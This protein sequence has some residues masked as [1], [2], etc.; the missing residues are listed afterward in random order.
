MTELDVDFVRRQFA[1]LDD[2]EHWAYFENAGGSL[3]PRQVTDKL[4]HFFEKTKVQPYYP[5]E[6]SEAAGDAMDRSQALL[7]ASVNASPAE[8]HFGPSTTMNVYVLAAA[9]RSQMSDGDEVIVT[10]QDHEANIGAWAR[11]ADTG[12]TVRTWEADEKSGFLDTDELTKLL[13]NRTRLVC[14][15]HCS[16]VVG[17][18]NPIREIAD[19]V[20]RAGAKI[21]VDGV[22][23]APHAPVDV[24]AL[25]VD[26]YLY[27]LYK[28]WGPHLGLMYVR[29][30]LAAELPNQGH[31]FNAGDAG[32][33]LVPAGP[34]HGEIA[35]ASGIVDY[36]DAIYTHHFGKP[37]GSVT[38]RVGAVFELFAK[39]E[40]ALTAML[41]QF[42]AD[43]PGIRVIGSLDPAHDKRA[44]TVS[45]VSE[46]TQ[47][48]IIVRTLAGKRIGAG[49]GNFYAYRLMERL[50]LDPQSGVTRL[51]FV[52]YNTAEEVGRALDVLAEVV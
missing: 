41:L 2:D 36:Y 47:N 1:Q 45:F 32:K 50:G 9:L 24:R 11:L 40:Q 20:H 5:Y 46:K 26:V 23:Y 21:I 25:D 29:E 52:H 27:S 38:E 39:H 15:T 34:D 14:V 7:S 33:R 19:T 28:T 4:R 13:T 3:A 16:N 10:S 30:E 44:P 43:R 37:T 22:S 18:I 31:F 35:A 42:L 6:P 51:S 49:Y 8:V 12:I 48:E 17:A